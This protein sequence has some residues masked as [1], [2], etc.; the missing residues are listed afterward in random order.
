MRCKTTEIQIEALTGFWAVE[1]EDG[2]PFSTG[3]HPG[4]R[5]KVSPER[6]PS[7]LPVLFFVTGPSAICRASLVGRSR[8]TP[9]AR[10]FRCLLVLIGR[11]GRGRPQSQGTVYHLVSVCS[12]GA[13]GEEQPFRKNFAEP[14]RARSSQ[15]ECIT[16]DTRD[17]VRR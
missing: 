5:W 7:G 2:T 9:S 11:L 12:V 8:R 13:V 4:R 14:N 10:Q 1:L 6:W 16:P 17:S 3:L 15:V